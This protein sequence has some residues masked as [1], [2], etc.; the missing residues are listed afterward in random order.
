MGSGFL[1][2]ENRFSKNSFYS[3]SSSS[4][5][6]SVAEITYIYILSIIARIVYNVIH[7]I[8]VPRRIKRREGFP[9]L[10]EVSQNDISPN[11][12]ANSNRNNAYTYN[13]VHSQPPRNLFA[14]SGA[15]HKPPYP[16]DTREGSY[17][18]CKIALLLHVYMHMGVLTYIRRV[19]YG[20]FLYE[21]LI[22]DV[23]NESVGRVKMPFCYW[24]A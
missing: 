24:L 15:W 2:E 16:F 1:E 19:C 18:I 17:I 8:P 9:R 4:F 14:A 5:S 21:E 23:F 10:S 7:N 20:C 6:Y 22:N 3:F 12:R 13:H 11:L